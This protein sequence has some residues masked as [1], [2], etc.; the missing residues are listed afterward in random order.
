MKL[1]GILTRN[2][3]RLTNFAPL[4]LIWKLII[5]FIHWDPTPIQTYRDLITNYINGKN[6]IKQI[7]M[8]EWS[9]HI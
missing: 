7:D 8:R 1:K 4:V 9:I 3:L 5:F 6:G 2:K